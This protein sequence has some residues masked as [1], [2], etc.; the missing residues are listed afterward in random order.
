MEF[1]HHE[2]KYGTNES[3]SV[4]KDNIIFYRYI[5]FISVAEIRKGYQKI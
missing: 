5:F 1:E 3:P 2:T 4:C